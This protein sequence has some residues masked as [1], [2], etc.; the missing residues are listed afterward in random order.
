MLGSSVPVSEF[1]QGQQRVLKE[2]QIA[3]VIA[4]SEM[5][6]ATDGF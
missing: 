5:S 4:S 6:T 2:K 3:T 1:L